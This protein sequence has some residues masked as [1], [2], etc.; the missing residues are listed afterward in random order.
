[1]VLLMV[2]LVLVYALGNQLIDVNAEHVLTLARFARRLPSRRLDRPVHV[3]TIHRWRRLGVGGICL[4]CVRIGAVWCT[5]LQAYSRWVERLTAAN[6][7][8]EANDLSTPPA[9]ERENR[10]E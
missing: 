5:S 9:R 7:Y 3:S 2:L 10:D 1:M 6:T 8:G 4:E